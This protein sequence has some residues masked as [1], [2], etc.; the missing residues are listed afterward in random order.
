M[1]D[2]RRSCLVYRWGLTDSVLDPDTATSL[3]CDLKSVT[4]PL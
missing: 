3:L 1:R 4:L 2:G